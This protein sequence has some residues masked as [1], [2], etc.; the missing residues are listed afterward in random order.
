MVLVLEMELVHVSKVTGA[1]PAPINA[2]A[3]L[4]HMLE[5]V[6]D[7]VFARTS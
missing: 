6:L 7:M 5:G 4:M 1:R 3:S 2:L